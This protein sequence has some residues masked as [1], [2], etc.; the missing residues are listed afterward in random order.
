MTNLRHARV[1][2]A[3]VAVLS[4]RDGSPSRRVRQLKPAA[5]RQLVGA[6]IARPLAPGA[7]VPTRSRVARA[8]TRPFLA[9]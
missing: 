6:A 5:L 1:G 7:S 8:G 2:A 4:K 3:T 9:L